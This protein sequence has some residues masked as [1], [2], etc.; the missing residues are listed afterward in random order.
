MGQFVMLDACMVLHKKGADAT[1]IAEAY[2]A[3][4]ESGKYTSVTDEAIEE[5][6][7]M[8]GEE[9]LHVYEF[10]VAVSEMWQRKMN[11]LYGRVRRKQ[12]DGR[13]CA[14][15]AVSGR[16]HPRRSR[17]LFRPALHRLPCQ[18]Q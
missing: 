5:I 6:I 2:L 8:S 11:F 3:I 12:W 4:S 13:G 7:S 18:E 9:G 16:A 1:K 10:L 15:P 14:G 17:G